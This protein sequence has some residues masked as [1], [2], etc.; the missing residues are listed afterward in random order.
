MKN[1]QL[2]ITKLI[3]EK[4]SLI[5][6]NYQ[7][8]DGFNDQY[9]SL[10]DAIK[11]LA[12]ETLNDCNAFFRCEDSIYLV[13]YEIIQ[14]EKYSEI[15]QRNYKYLFSLKLNRVI[16]KTAADHETGGHKYPGIYIDFKV[17]E[18]NQTQPKE[19][20]EEFTMKD[21]AE[22]FGGL[23]NKISKESIFIDYHGNHLDFSSYEL[24]KKIKIRDA[25][26]FE[27]LSDIYCY[28]SIC[29]DLYYVAQSNKYHGVFD[30]NSREWIKKESYDQRLIDQP[31]YINYNL[32]NKNLICLVT[33]KNRFTF[34][35]KKGNEVLKFEEFDDKQYCSA[36]LNLDEAHHDRLSLFSSS[37][38]SEIEVRFSMPDIIVTAEEIIIKCTSINLKVNESFTLR[39]S[40][41]GSYKFFR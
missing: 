21:F 34:I 23:A 7:V 15:E 28:T 39:I 41:R 10:W 12:Q 37:F 13:E 4:N 8:K 40:E 9:K 24:N 25:F 17:L 2:E 31:H 1:K 36:I 30:V 16:Y 11:G 35:D 27:I 26:D 3:K 14:F 33:S 5:D 19:L 20:S 38:R 29:G 22:A 6:S 32:T 18:I